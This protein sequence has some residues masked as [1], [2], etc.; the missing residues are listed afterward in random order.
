[1]GGGR[2][3]GSISPFHLLWLLCSL[4][5]V[6]CFIPINRVHTLN[7]S[8]NPPR[9]VRRFDSKMNS[10]MHAQ[11][12]PGNGASTTHPPMKIPVEPAPF[13]FCN[14]ELNGQ[15]IEAIGF[16]M[17]FTLAQVYFV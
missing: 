2:L 12:S 16:D 7:R 8:L 14:V 10:Q 1:M 13:I 4:L 6:W 5:S 9:I 3:A 17:D 11:C 15:A